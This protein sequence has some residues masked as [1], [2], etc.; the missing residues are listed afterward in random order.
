MKTWISTE[1]PENVNIRRILYEI[2]D[3]SFRQ[4]KNYELRT[5][6]QI[7][8]L[9]DHLLSTVPY[10][11][12][13]EK[14]K[15]RKNNKASQMRRIINYIDTHYSQKLLLSEIA[16]Q[17]NLSLSYL[18]HFFHQA[19][20][21]PFQSYLMK[22][23][24]EKARRLLLCTQL[25]LLDICI[26]CGFSDMK[27]FNNGFLKQYGHTPREYRTLFDHEI[28]QIQQDTMLTTQDILSRNA[29]FAILS[30]YRNSF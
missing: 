7:N 20:G 8:L 10:E 28:L 4:P 21:M 15:S 18:S 6:A 14:E 29:S 25:P 19:F 12:I 2:A 9:F 1:T 5:V 16:E 24:C 11:I 26:A 22:M 27:Y 3:L 17:E 23:R 30:R 13:P